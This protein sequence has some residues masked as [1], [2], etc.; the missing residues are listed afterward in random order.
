MGTISVHLISA[1]MEISIWLDECVNSGIR[2]S[3]GNALDSVLR[4]IVIRVE[5]CSSLPTIPEGSMLTG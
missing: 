1:P 5:N 4:L 2:C 3:R